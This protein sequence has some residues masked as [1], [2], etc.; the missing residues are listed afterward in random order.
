MV[1]WSLIATATLLQGDP[2]AA[3][4]TSPYV[5]YVAS[6]RVCDAPPVYVPGAGY[7]SPDCP[8]PAAI[9]PYPAAPV[10]A[11]SPAPA[12]AFAP[13]LTTV[14]PW[15]CP[16]RAPFVAAYPAGV[17]AVTPY[18]FTQYPI[19]YYPHLPCCFNDLRV[20]TKWHMSPGNM[21]PPLAGAPAA[22]GNYYFKPYNYTMVPYQ[23]HAAAQWGE[24]PAQPYLGPLQDT[25]AGRAAAYQA[26]LSGAPC[27]SPP[28][29]RQPALNFAPAEPTLPASDYFH[30]EKVDASAFP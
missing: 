29:N 24:S 25:L 22:H 1:I 15:R 27:C 30:H 21:L 23:Q 6:E 8:P 10:L 3:F 4:A 28:P 16:C 7:G 26:A 9:C 13:S 5:P 2:G 11:V 14:V 20:R 12:V 17:V 19:Y 18:S